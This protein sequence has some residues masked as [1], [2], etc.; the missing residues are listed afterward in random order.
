MF[1]IS[2]FFLFSLAQAKIDKGPKDHV[3]LGVCPLASWTTG[4]CDG[5]K[6]TDGLT[7]TKTGSGSLNWMAYAGGTGR[8][9]KAEKISLGLQVFAIGDIETK[10][11]LSYNRPDSADLNYTIRG[12][13]AVGAGLVVGFVKKSYDVVRLVLGIERR[14]FG[15]DTT[16]GDFTNKADIEA[17]AWRVNLS[18]RHKLPCRFALSYVF[19]YSIMGFMRPYKLTKGTLDVSTG[20]RIPFSLGGLKSFALD[21]SL[22]LGL[23]YTF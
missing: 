21:Q 15:L 10:G 11:V 16:V 18:V 14:P 3:F 1:F 20:Q 6:A 4:W 23:E 2:V 19:G 22:F 7:G 12:G 8:F 9:G 17:Y 5:L 13:T